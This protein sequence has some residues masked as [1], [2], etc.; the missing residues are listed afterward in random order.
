MIPKIIKMTAFVISLV[1]IYAGAINLGFSGPLP[2]IPFLVV[3]IIIGSRSGSGYKIATFLVIAISSSLY[4][5]KIKHGDIF[6]P[7]TGKEVTLSEASC[8]VEIDYVGD[9]EKVLS[10]WPVSSGY[11]DSPIGSSKVVEDLKEGSLYTVSKTKVTHPDFSEK[12][13]VMLDTKHGSAEVSVSHHEGLLL[14][15]EGDKVKHSDLYRSI[16]YYPSLVMY[17]PIAPIAA[18]GLIL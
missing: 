5:T 9:K 3:A 7:I 4:I 13:S 18:I 11:C 6:Y 2:A 15:D 16:F 1:G 14:D 17:W 8:L 10:I 12:Y